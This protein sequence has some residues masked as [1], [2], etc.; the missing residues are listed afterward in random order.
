MSYI[1]DGIEFFEVEYGTDAQC[2]RCGS[3]VTLVE[4]TTLDGSGF[5]G[6]VCL[7]DP[8][9]CDAHPLPGREQQMGG[10]GRPLHRVGEGSR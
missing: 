1:R 7:S 9:W 10:H 8:E 3:S 5:D 2:A 4:D 6:H